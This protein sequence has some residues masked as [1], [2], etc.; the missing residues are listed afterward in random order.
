M[1]WYY[2]E[3]GSRPLGHRPWRRT[4]IIP[5][6]LWREHLR[7]RLA[8]KQKGKSGRGGTRTHDLTDVNPKIQGHVCDVI[9]LEVESFNN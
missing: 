9:L 3:H 5:H 4:R 2:L 8:C 6:H 1:T 7:V